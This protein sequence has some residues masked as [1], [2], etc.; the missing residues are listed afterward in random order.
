MLDQVPFSAYAICYGPLALTIIGFI[1]F[2]AITDGD[3]RRTYLRDLDPRARTTRKP[4]SRYGNTETPSGVPV[5]IP[6][7]DDESQ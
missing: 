2:A 7:P 1:V 3:A 5:T 6:A 4:K